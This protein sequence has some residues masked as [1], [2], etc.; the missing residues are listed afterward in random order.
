MKTKLVIWGTNEKEERV[1]LAME[2]LPEQNEVT[3]YAFPEASATD[4][5]VA[6]MMG[7]WRDGISVPF[8]EDH[9]EI[10]RPLAMAESLL[11]DDFR[12][13]RGDVVQRAQSEWAFVVLSY[14]LQKSLESELDGLSEKVHAMQ[15][16]SGGVWDELKGFWDKVMVQAR[17]RNLFREHIEQLREK[18]NGL[19]DH[20][21][22]LRKASETKL[23]QQSGEIAAAFNEKLDDVFA[24][25]TD[26]K[27]LINLFET[28][29]RLQREY[30]D[31]ALTRDDRNKL[32]ARMDEAFKLVKE[33]RFGDKPGGGAATKNPGSRIEGRLQGLLDAIGK[34]Q[35]S[36]E[37]DEKDLHFENKRIDASGGQLEVQLRQAKLAMIQDRVDSKK[38]KLADM[39]KTQADLES[40]AAEAEERQKAQE[41]KRKVDA[42]AKEIKDRIARE[43]Q[44][45]GKELEKSAEE[46]EAA[47]RG[48]AAMKNK[49]A[50]VKP[51]TDAKPAEAAT[52]AEESSTAATTEESAATE[53]V[54]ESPSPEAA[55]DTNIA[56]QATE[57]PAES[58][59]E[60]AHSADDEETAV[61][62]VA[63][64]APEAPEVHEETPVDASAD[65][66]ESASEQEAEDASN[67]VEAT[68]EA[69]ES[70]EED[71][72]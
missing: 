56:E 60:V 1:L 47:A 36:I 34:M 53:V 7:N 41:E 25:V 26:G 69:T 24:K 44:E 22:T 43:I 29:K 13:E 46:L 21:K 67:E 15:E 55:E 18:S 35:K 2:L 23:R 37:R 31:L 40:K 30:H 58:N 4:E 8:P 68:T 14:K 42:A 49:G 64:E 65:T 62:E 12:V 51:A 70:P 54:A 20:L 52:P 11:P 16:F 32:W 39:L 59:E 6:Q 27:H 28:L 48:I 71:K 50:R 19:F 5:F 10:R 61:S 17:D 9:Q 3:L 63:E 57:A 45:S 33:K 38:E 72:A 66:E